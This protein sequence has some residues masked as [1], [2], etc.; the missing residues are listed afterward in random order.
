[1]YFTLQTLKTFD[2]INSSM[3]IEETQ[4]KEFILDSGLVSRSDVTSAEKEAK[5]TKSSIGKVLVSKGKLTEDEKF[6]AKEDLQK[7]IDD[8][9]HIPNKAFIGHRRKIRCYPIK[10]P[11]NIYNLMFIVKVTIIYI[12]I[13]LMV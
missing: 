5:E 12:F 11:V 6:R 10:S 9:C 4:L 7:I 3:H 13:F 8:I 2:F 1:M